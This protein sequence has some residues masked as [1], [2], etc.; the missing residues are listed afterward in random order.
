VW[1]VRISPSK[2]FQ[3]AQLLALSIFSLKR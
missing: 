2:K 1:T 3:I